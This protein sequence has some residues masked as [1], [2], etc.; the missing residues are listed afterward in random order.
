MAATTAFFSDSFS[1]YVQMDTVATHVIANPGR[2]LTIVNI[3]AFNSSGTA[4]LT[5]QKTGGV[6]ILTAATVATVSGAWKDMPIDTANNTLSATD[7]IT[8]VTAA[9][10]I[11]Q[12]ILEC[13][14][15]TGST[16]TWDS[17]ET[18]TVT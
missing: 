18:L 13:I 10:T 17:K 6:N 14:A 3:K 5:V 1:I 4:N 11:T 7:S 15:G 2:S 16:N 9:T 8:I 12:V